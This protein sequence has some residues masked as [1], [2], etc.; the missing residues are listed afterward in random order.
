M[1]IIPFVDEQDFE[2]NKSQG[3]ALQMGVWL[4]VWIISLNTAWN[5]IV[6]GSLH[7][8]KPLWWKLLKPELLEMFHGTVNVSKDPITCHHPKETA[9]SS[10]SPPQQQA[11]AFNS[12]WK[13][14]HWGL[15]G[16]FLRSI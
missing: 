7:M 12:V 5:S 3:T 4:G 6:C 11:L 9:S 16:L 13:E 1:M 15:L 14:H 8:E 2:C 10:M